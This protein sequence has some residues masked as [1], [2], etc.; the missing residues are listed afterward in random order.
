VCYE[1]LRKIVEMH[2]NN[3][4]NGFVVSA[5]PSVGEKLQSKEFGALTKT[6]N[7]VGKSIKIQI[8]PLYSQENFNV[9]MM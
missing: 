8:N 9:V 2:R 7:F 5:S 4:A 6:A 3:D 1:I